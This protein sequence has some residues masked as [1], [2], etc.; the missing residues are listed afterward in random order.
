MS[1]KLY[2]GNAVDAT[3]TAGEFA[4]SA[5]YPVNN[6]K[7][8]NANIPAS[9]ADTYN[10]GAPVEAFSLAIA[11]IDFGADTDVSFSVLDLSSFRVQITT[12]MQNITGASLALY[13]SDNGSDYTQWKIFVSKTVGAMSMDETYSGIYTVLDTEITHRYYA[14]V[15]Y[16]DLEGSDD[17]EVILSGN[18]NNLYLGDYLTLPD[19]DFYPTGL[20]HNT[21]IYTSYTGHRAGQ[22]A[23]GQRKAYKMVFENLSSTQRTNIIAFDDYTKGGAYPVYL[24]HPGIISDIYARVIGDIEIVPTAYQNYTCAMT[25]EEEL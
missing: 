10:S 21:Q 7:I 5:Q 19:P 17:V 1:V 15:L 22:D 20:G 3:V 4:Y 11:K 6:L 8:L 2:Y 14:L 24:S 25:L 18:I 9:P 12:G 13:Y 23:Q 16:I